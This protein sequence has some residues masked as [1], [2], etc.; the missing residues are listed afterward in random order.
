MLLFVS[1][2]ERDPAL[3]P[4]VWP[5]ASS[6]L[7]ESPNLVGTGWHRA[8]EAS[9]G[10][11]ARA[12]VWPRKPAE[13]RRAA[14]V[15]GGE[16]QSWPHGSQT[17]ALPAPI[18]RHR[19]GRLGLSEEAGSSLASGRGG[20]GRQQPRK[21]EQ[22]EATGLGQVCLPVRNRAALPCSSHAISASEV[23]GV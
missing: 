2:G 5:T 4:A 21:L 11:V 12:H 19:W 3:L 14:A 15:L 18:S 8:P 17:K 22:K 23:L 10:S 6:H 16:G 1:L 9:L 13:G 7:G 20:G